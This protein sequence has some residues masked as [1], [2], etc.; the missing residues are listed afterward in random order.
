MAIA[1]VQTT[2]R[3]QTDASSATNFDL[4]VVSAVSGNAL[5]YLSAILD[6]G[7]DTWTTG[8]LSDGGNTWT[9]RECE[10]IVVATQKVRGYVGWAV[11]ITG[12]TRTVNIT[13]TGASAGTRYLWLGCLEFSGVATSAAEDTWDANSNVDYFAVDISAGPITTTDAGDVLV[14]TA[15]LISND[16]TLNWASPTSWT[17]SYRE[18]DGSANQN[19]DA[20]YWLP[21]A[22]QTTYTAQWAHDNVT[23]EAGAVVV[24]LKPVAA[25]VGGTLTMAKTMVA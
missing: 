3:V 19:I 2:T 10:A 22:I 9:V 4:S 21:A 11:G 12:G 20:G 5:T 6:V 8:T 13:M 14:G 25:A 7:N 15:A 16:T 1:L 18:G 17:N 23:S 24:A